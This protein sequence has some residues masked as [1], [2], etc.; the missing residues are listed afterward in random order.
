[1]TTLASLLA[2]AKSAVLL[3]GSATVPGQAAP[4]PSPTGLPSADE[5]ARYLQENPEYAADVVKSS[6]EGNSSLVLGWVVLAAVLAVGWFLVKRVAAGGGEGWVVRLYRRL[7]PWAQSLRVWFALAPVTFVY[8]ATWTVTTV[9]FQGT[10]ETLAGVVNRFNSTNIVGLL[11]DPVRVLFS[12]AFIVA[13]YGYFFIGYVAVYVL[14]VARLE[15]RIGSARVLLVGA[16][17]HVLGSLLT[18]A[19]EVVAIRADLLSKSMV[20]T[21]DVGVSYVMVG[22]CGAYLFLVGRRWR[23]WFAGALAV[24]VVLPLV[25]VQSIW[26]LGHFLAT[27]SGI[28]LYLIV[29]RWGLRDQVTWREV[30]A[31]HPARPLPT[32]PGEPGRGDAGRTGAGGQV[33]A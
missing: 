18:V 5:L 6:A 16:G 23:W 20:L 7:D 17:S 30:V 24:G 27:C 14:I 13:D 29:R 25:A 4:S 19:V 2:G 3:S 1:V 11:N 22:T 9:I 15:Q 32:W 33:V 31:A 21:Q 8:V 12:S 28:G 10:P 26:N